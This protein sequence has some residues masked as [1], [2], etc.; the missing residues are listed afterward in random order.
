M[1]FEDFVRLIPIL[2][3]TLGCGGL[4]VAV[5]FVF[6]INN[7]DIAVNLFS[8]TARILYFFRRSRQKAI[9]ASNLST[10]LNLALSILQ[11]EIP[12]IFPQSV[13]IEWIEDDPCVP[14]W[15][16]QLRLKD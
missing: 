7:L 11:K 9:L 2:V 10:H 12:T 8:F 1:N 3:P 6:F 16:K 13:R 5:I 14:Q 4:I 15:V